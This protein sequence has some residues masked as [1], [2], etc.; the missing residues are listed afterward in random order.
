M[1]GLTFANNG[2]ALEA[3]LALAWGYSAFNISLKPDFVYRALNDPDFDGE[4]EWREYVA[5]QQMLTGETPLLAD[6]VI[7][8]LVL[9]RY[10]EI[11]PTRFTLLW[12]LP[13]FPEYSVSSHRKRVMRE[14]GMDKYWRA[15]GF[16]PQCRAVGDSDFECD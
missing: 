1:F 15:R 7:A 9:G 11:P 16:P 6:N 12:W 3:K 2:M 14:L 13:G 4:F 10:D 5:R 8:A